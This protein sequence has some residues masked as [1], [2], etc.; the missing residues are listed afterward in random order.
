MIFAELGYVLFSLF[1]RDKSGSSPS[2][3]ETMTAKDVF[4]RYLDLGSIHGLPYL[5]SA[6][7]WAHQIPWAI[8][9]LGALVTGIYFVILASFDFGD[10][11]ISNTVHLTAKTIDQVQFPTVTICPVQRSDPWAFPRLLLN[12]AEIVDKD[13]HAL[14][15][16]VNEDL[17]GFWE[18]L[19][20]FHWLSD[21][22][23]LDFVSRNSFSREDAI[24][25]FAHHAQD[26]NF[27]D[28]DKM[29]FESKKNRSYKVQCQGNNE[30]KEVSMAWP[31]QKEF[32]SVAINI[33]LNGTSNINGLMTTGTAE[34]R[35]NA[36]N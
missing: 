30:D 17:S 25:L 12:Q 3:E 28:K 19:R 32:N 5:S 31:T 29:F 6:R 9:V 14:K 16:W 13:S 4:R 34:R 15:A 22:Y 8:I 35:D 10:N 24:A 7:S 2:A 20:D 33:V 23:L 21:G 1:V 18:K 11:A 36:T 27:F 26:P